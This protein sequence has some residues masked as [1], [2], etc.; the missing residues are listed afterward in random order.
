MP[1]NIFD[2]EQM[3][4]FSLEAIASFAAGHTTETFYGFSVDATMLCLNS[5]EAFQE[6]LAEYQAKW[7]GHYTDPKKILE[8][9]NNQ[10]DWKYQG[11]ADLGD[12]GFDHEAYDWHYD[13][14]EEEQ[15][16][17]AYAVAMDQLVAALVERD[18]FAALRRTDDFFVNRVEHNY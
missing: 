5:E 10:G 16:A 15:T 9:K 12:H 2:H 7:P 18:A 17:T 3:L 1:T 11:F 6:T 13:S 8:L 4:A 14:P